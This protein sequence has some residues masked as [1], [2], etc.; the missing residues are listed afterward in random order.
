M[1]SMAV[2]NTSMAVAQA[3]MAVAQ[4]SMAVAQA[5]VAHARCTDQA[6]GAYRARR[7]HNMVVLLV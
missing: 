3:S 2:A 6:G 1:L 7:V 4:A 5:V